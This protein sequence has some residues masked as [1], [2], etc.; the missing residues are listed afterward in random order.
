[1]GKKIPNFSLL[2]SYCCGA[3]NW[4]NNVPSTAELRM[5]RHRNGSIEPGDLPQMI[6]TLI[7][8]ANTALLQD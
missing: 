2:E 8:C 5:P 3:A 7:L 4:E 1:M 6:R